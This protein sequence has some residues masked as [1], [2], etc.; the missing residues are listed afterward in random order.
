V[1][2]LVEFLVDMLPLDPAVR[3]ATD[4]A[5][6]DWEYEE[7]ERPSRLQRA[8]IAIRGAWSLVAVLVH[9]VGGGLFSAS[10]MRTCALCLAL[11]VAFGIVL[12]FIWIFSGAWLPLP[13]ATRLEM[14]AL[15]APW[16]VGTTLP[17]ALL[18]LVSLG[19]GSSLITAC[20]WLCAVSFVSLG[21]VVPGTNQAFR[22]RAALHNTTLPPGSTGLYLPRGEA[23]LSLPVLLSRSNQ[24]TWLGGRAWT[25]LQ[26]R[27]MLT[28]LLPV[29]LL[30]GTQAVR[31]ARARRWRVGG[32]V[33][34][35]ATVIAAYGL[36]ALAAAAATRIVRSGSY[37][38]SAELLLTYRSW[39]LPGVM[40]VA[41]ML[42]ARLAH[43]AECGTM[44]VVKPQQ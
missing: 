35:G 33:L 10:T 6:A 16:A 30:A 13:V 19:R 26:G 5:L 24:D 43:R 28:A 36:Y 7:G 23:E 14:L 34:S 22:E 25:H 32:L 9:S 39:L 18:T 1:R 11:A 29:C 42:L 41:S 27:L 37:V 15:L 21:W 38:A 8:R 2:R 4:E 20:V 44:L 17:L 40:I 31:L 3:R 12:P